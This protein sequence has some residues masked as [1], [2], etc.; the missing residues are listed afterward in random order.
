MDIS[1]VVP[2]PVF[3]NAELTLAGS[4]DEFGNLPFVITLT[5]QGQPI[6]ATAHTVVF[7]LHEIRPFT[8]GAEGIQT[9]GVDDLG[10]AIANGFGN[11]AGAMLCLY[12]GA[13]VAGQINHVAHGNYQ[14]GCFLPDG[15]VALSNV[16]TL[17]PPP[18]PA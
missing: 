5:R 15:G 4:V 9:T 18:P 16:V 1:F 17:A 10:M 11:P 8:G 3:D 12:R 14:V 2:E 6:M 13:P 7:S